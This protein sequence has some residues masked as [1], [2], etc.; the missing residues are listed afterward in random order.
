MFT[1]KLEQIKE[2]TK[3]R[4]WQEEKRKLKVKFKKKKNTKKKYTQNRAR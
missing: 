1:V 2:R 3:Q 4:G